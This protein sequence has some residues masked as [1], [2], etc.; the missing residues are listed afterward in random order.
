MGDRMTGGVESFG[1]GV[2]REGGDTAS[3]VVVARTYRL[4]ER[5]GAGGMAD[6]YEA[7]HLR[8]GNRVAVKLLRAGGRA[9]RS[10]IERFRHEAR[11]VA[12]LSSEHIV[13]VFDCGRLPCGTPYLVMERLIGEDLRSLLARE[14]RLPVRRA[15]GLA[16]GACRGLSVV[17]AAGLVHRDL[18]PAN[19]FVVRG[20]TGADWCKILD[21]GVAKAVLSDATAG[22]A[23][24]GTV[25]YMAPEQLEDAA[26]AR[27]GADIY[28]VGAILYECLTGLPPHEGRTLH[29]LM[30][31][32]VHRE[33]TSISKYRPIPRELEEVVLRALSRDPTLRFA[34][35][36]EFALA[37]APFGVMAPALRT[38]ERA[39][40]ATLAD[41]EPTVAHRK[42]SSSR[43][44]WFWACAAVMVAV[45]ALP[46]SSGHTQSRPP[47]VTLPRCV[48]GPLAR[49]PD[50]GR[51]S[52]G[53][54]ISIS[55]EPHGPPAVMPAK[56][57]DSALPPKARARPRN[58]QVPSA[59][60]ASP[61]GRFDSKDPYSE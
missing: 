48:E 55:S 49:E 42:R 32:I 19:L 22:G 6:V 5:L 31:D 52:S 4:L 24:L 9:D 28:A 41:V 56:P 20:S 3:G 13:K 27:A 59:L 7:E 37:L 47:S 35:A 36:D 15:V 60:L 11:R 1:S 29:E 43:T 39:G 18:K 58:Q 8:L 53:A 38:V 61:A 10:G 25:R 30:Y 51:S 57:R 44:R 21:F 46:Q 33:V 54:P 16:V 14:G 34:S 26:S 17:H 12:A 40:D 23:L 50:A 2:S 45:V